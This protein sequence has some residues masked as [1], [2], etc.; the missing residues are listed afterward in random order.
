MTKILILGAGSFFTFKWIRDILNTPSPSEGT[1]ALVD[2]DPQR[3]STSRKMAEKMVEERN[4]EGWKVE[5]A[6][7]RE[8]LMEESDFII[9][10]IEA[11][12]VDTV[13]YDYEIPKKYGV[14]Q[15]IGDTVGPGGV[16]K[17]LRTAPSWIDILRDAEQLSPNALILNYTNPMAMI[18]LAATETT[19]LSVV[20]LCHS[21]QNTSR[22]LAE[23]A[24]VPY[25]EMRWKC[26]GINH[27]SWFTELTHKGTNLYPKLRK[28]AQNPQIYRK[29]PVRFETM[30]Q[31]GYFP[32]E[33]SGHFSEYVPY[34]RK[35]LELI[36]EYCG[37]EYKGGSGFYA[38]NWPEWRKA[39]DK[40]MRKWIKGEKIGEE[41]LENTPLEEKD[42]D[43]SWRSQEYASYIIE[44]NT[45]D[46]PFIFH[47]NVKNTG[48]IENLPKDGIVE[49]PVVVDG[50]EFHPCRFGRLPEHLASL[51]RSNMSV[52]RLVIESILESDREKAIRAMMMDPLTAAVGSLKEIRDMANELFE[53]EKDYLPDYLRD[54]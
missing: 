34:F 10:T 29:D 39:K 36:E 30:L 20:G 7:E 53:A 18:T 2:I 28:K 38:K 32:T 3:L 49:V 15:C 11:S 27:M 47:G 17:A 19:E 6:T 14:D 40:T 46:R 51:N 41:E 9:N 23:Y 37:T 26:G 42:L 33:S 13:K 4:A 5:S 21:V 52:Q 31:L 12:G 25:E 22:Q 8:R 35:R 45:T 16:M 54:S 50:S 44:A 48:L 43:L 24:G 1:F